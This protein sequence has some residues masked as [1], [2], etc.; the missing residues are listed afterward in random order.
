MNIKDTL[1][2]AEIAHKNNQLQLAENLYS[3]VIA[4]NNHIDAIYG[5]AT[6]YMQTKKL[7]QA[8]EL[9]SKAM[10]IEPFAI[11]IGYNFLLCL[12]QQDKQQQAIVL[13]KTLAPHLLSNAEIA[14]AYAIKAWQ[15]GDI[16]LSVEII[17][18]LAQHNKSLLPQLAQLIML[19]EKWA[20]AI[21][22]WQQ[23]LMIK[24]QD[25]AAFKNLSICYAKLNDYP[26]AIALFRQVIAIE[27]SNENLLKLADLYL[28]AQDRD[29]AQLCLKQAVNAGDVSFERYEIECKIARLNQNNKAAIQAATKA[30]KI[31]P[32]ASFAWKVLQEFSGTQNSKQ[33]IEELT[34]IIETSNASDF[35]TQQNMFTVAKA[36][37][38]NQDYDDAF[39]FFKRANDSQYQRFANSERQYLYQEQESVYQN[40]AR[41]NYQ[42]FFAEHNEEV[43]TEH[44][45]IVGMPRSGTTLLN[46]IISQHSDC[47]SCNEST[48]IT[49]LFDHLLTRTDIQPSAKESSLA[50]LASKASALYREKTKLASKVT[51]DKMP[52]NFRYIGAI[53]STFSTAKILQMRRHPEDLALSIF[54]NQFNDYHNYACQLDTIAHAI[55]LANQLMDYWKQQFPNQVVDVDYQSLSQT[56]D[57]TA[58]AVFK[59]CQLAWSDQ[60]LE[61]YKDV[62]P[63]YTFSELQVRQPINTKKI[64]FSQ[65]YHQQLTGFRKAY[66]KYSQQNLLAL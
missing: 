16:E 47:K 52:H 27:S 51:V 30:L 34:Q 6:L 59:F 58:A 35:E 40:I 28:L 31:Q 56:P 49:E 39:A 63:S 24:S 18:P 7:T 26:Q 60:Y 54:S 50:E 42:N 36:L 3:A 20:Q 23:Y 15:L 17:T 61:F 25:V 46:R 43:T 64:N 2:K 41:L 5:L 53:I 21:D 62:V 55:A 8:S 10:T 66:T 57:K 9:F 33:L 14:H 48:A 65:H 29:N 19:T 11:D 12:M 22:T 44:I 38:N 45:F 1:N 37:E 4:N 32:T 13:I